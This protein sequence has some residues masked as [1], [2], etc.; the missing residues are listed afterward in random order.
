MKNVNV[1]TD[2]R[3]DVRLDQ[4]HIDYLD[5]VSDERDISRAALIRKWLAA[6]E[7]AESVVIP[8]FDDPDISGSTPQ[9]S[10]EQLLLSELPDT[11]DEAITVDE[12]REKLKEKIDGR[13]M[14]LYR[15]SDNIVVTSGGEMYADE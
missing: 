14:K 7:R 13:V 4:D 1:N 6:G 3:L 11:Q 2:P 15:E 9:G 8:G 10:V 5:E 12:I